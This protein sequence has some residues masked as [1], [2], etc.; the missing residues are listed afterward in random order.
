M[1]GGVFHE[2]TTVEQAAGEG[3]KFKVVTFG[4]GDSEDFSLKEYDIADMTS[5]RD[6]F[7]MEKNCNGMHKELMCHCSSTHPQV[8]V[9]KHKPR[10][11]ASHEEFGLF[12]EK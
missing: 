8:F 1:K 7:P 9:H 2:F 10:D 12:E 11:R 6:Q 4:R 3:S 5:S